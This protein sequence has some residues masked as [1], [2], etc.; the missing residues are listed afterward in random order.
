M[1]TTRARRSGWSEAVN[2]AHDH[3]QGTC[4][5]QAVVA[6]RWT[7]SLCNDEEGE[8]S[9]VNGESKKIKVI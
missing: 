2:Y 8:E 3:V 9:G 6:Q 5:T 7:S 4:T 1:M